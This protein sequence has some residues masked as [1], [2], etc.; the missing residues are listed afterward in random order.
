MNYDRQILISTGNSRKDISWRSE[1]LKVSELYDRLRTP[2]RGTETLAEYMQMNKAQ[3]VALKDVGGFMAGSLNGGRRKTQNV[4]GR[5]VITLDFDACPVWSADVIKGKLDMA[6]YGYA[7]YPTR[8]HVANAPR[9]RVLVPTDRTMTPDEY[10]PCARRV[11][12]QIGISMADP[13]T[14]EVAR[15]MYWPS[16]CADSEY[17]LWTADKPLVSVDGL[18]A[19]YEDWHDFRSWPQVPGS[20]NYTKLKNQ[21]EDPEAKK[22]VVGAF[23]RAYDV[24]RAMDELIPGTYVP[25]DDGDDNR[26]SYAHGS[27]TGGAVVYDDGKFI[28]SHHATDP[29][30]GR[31]VNAFDL[32][33]LHKF[34]DQD[35]DANDDAPASK[36]PSYAAMLTYANTLDEVRLALMQERQKQ[37]V[38]DFQSVVDEENWMLSLKCHPK[39]GLPL[40]TI[41]NVR[42]ILEHD[43]LLKDKFA[44]NEFAGRGEVRGALPWC[45]EGKRRLWSD[46]DNNGLYWYMEDRYE[47]S[48]R[49]AIDAALDVHAAT[50]AFNEVREYLDNLVWD[51][52]PRLDT[53]F[54]DYLGADNSEYTKAVTRKAF[55][56]A[57]ARALTPGCKHDCMLILC[58]KQGLGKSTLLDKMS[59]G[60]FNDS[61]RSFEGKDASE[62]L[63]GVWIVEIAEL[64]A[65]RRSDVSCIKQFLSL[66]ADRYRAAYGRNVKELP[67]RCA[68]FGTCNN[69]DFLQ[70]TTGNRRFWPVDVGVIPNK[71]T[72]F[73]DL[74]DEVI[75]QLWAEA[76]ARW[77]VGEELFLTG[78]VEQEALDMQEAHREADA[79]ESMIA[80]FVEREIP[81]NWDKM[82]A[83]SQ[84]AFLSGAVVG[85]VKLVKRDRICAHEVWCELYGKQAVDMSK[86]DSREINAALSL[87]PGW[88]RTTSNIRFGRYGKQRGFV[89]DKA[90]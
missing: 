64:D 56:G 65:F 60:F 86:R 33:R 35:A 11:A 24:F 2:S 75:E 83:A 52:V 7:I 4:L 10:E 42:L 49:T 13:T 76:K 47:I 37:A 72:V 87:I 73:K 15:L 89:R 58:G 29:C 1:T 14:F 16:C 41:N 66:R 30:S 12:E 84:Q 21:Q 54:T 31:L 22:G 27:T 32:V 62:L 88:S 50:H 81:E 8:K 77:L 44:L 26:F 6:G 45:E 69:F 43:P 20:F 19:T 90:Q 68:F 5:D 34:G 40:E 28:F 17:F 70:D 38:A 39:T 71:Y 55:V 48:K 53:L 74:T 61:I 46:T 25:T 51:G 82:P 36:L 79:R 80:E 18:L 85:D 59:R 9:L 57:V 67:R 3:Q 63:Q 78:E 23:C